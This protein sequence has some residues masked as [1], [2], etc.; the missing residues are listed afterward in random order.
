MTPDIWTGLFLVAIGG[1]L[2]LHC[3]RATR[4]ELRRGVARDDLG[5]AYSRD[6]HPLAFR[7]VIALNLAAVLLGLAFL[8]VGATFL[9]AEAFGAR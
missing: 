8:C 6:K 3:S 2:A 1:L 5:I 7:I 9:L 4:R